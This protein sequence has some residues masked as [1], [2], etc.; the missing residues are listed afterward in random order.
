M[1]PGRTRGFFICQQPNLSFR[2]QRGIRPFSEGNGF[3]GA[4]PQNDRTSAAAAVVAAAA[5]VV[6]AAAAVVAATAV[7]TAA[8]AAVVDAAAAQKQNDHNDDPPTA[9]KTVIAHIATSCKRSHAGD[10]TVSRQASLSP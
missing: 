8:P 10:G 2:A 5:A 7:V 9:V 4:R 6:V 1:S 3:F